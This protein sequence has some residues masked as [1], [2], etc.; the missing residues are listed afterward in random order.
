MFQNQPFIDPLQ[1]RC[2]WIIHKIHRKKPVLESLVDKVAVLR[3]YNFI[4]ESLVNKVPVLKTCNSIKEDSDTDAFLW[5]LQT[6]WEQLFLKTSVMS[7]SKLYLKRD[8]S[9]GVFQWILRIIQEHL[10]CRG[11]TNSWF[12]ST[13]AWV[14]P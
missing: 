1:N 2:S 11:S 7:A 6:S 12:W 13:R 9:T 14:S 4:K 3:T 8:F 10:Y 5:N